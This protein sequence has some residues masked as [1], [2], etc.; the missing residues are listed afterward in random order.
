MLVLGFLES[1]ADDE[2]RADRWGGRGARLS[3]AG[4]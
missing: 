1:Q 4:R 2:G 3:S